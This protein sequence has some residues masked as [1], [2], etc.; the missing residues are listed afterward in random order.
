MGPDTRFMNAYDILG[1]PGGKMG[2]HLVRGGDTASAS[3]S[4]GS[5]AG[6]GVSSVSFG[7]DTVDT[8]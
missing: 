1:P 7:G 8:H 4:A 6:L 2:L 5:E 3:S